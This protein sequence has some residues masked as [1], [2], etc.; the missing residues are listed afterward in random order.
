MSMM[1]EYPLAQQAG[2]T[3]KI[4]HSMM[5]LV[6]GFLH[7]SNLGFQA[8]HSWSEQQFLLNVPPRVWKRHSALLSLLVD[9]AEI[10]EAQ[11]SDG[12]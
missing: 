6:R 12:K 11:H 10:S 9:Q 2:N 3:D 8:W 4:V 1:V 7:K 5:L